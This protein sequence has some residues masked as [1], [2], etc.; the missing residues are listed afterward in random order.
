MAQDRILYVCSLCADENP[1]S[2][3]HYFTKDLVVMTDGRWLCEQC[4]DDDLEALHA[5]DAHGNRKPWSIFPHPPEY[6]PIEA[7]K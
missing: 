7:A 5:E 3:G 2:C 1:E 6:G 4:F